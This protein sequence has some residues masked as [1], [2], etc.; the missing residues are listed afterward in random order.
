LNRLFV[1]S[2]KCC[3]VA[4]SL[5]LRYGYEK[6][7]ICLQ[8]SVARQVLS[9]C[10]S[11]L[12]NLK[13]D[14]VVEPSLIPSYKPVLDNLVPLV[15]DVFVGPKSDVAEVVKCVLDNLPLKVVEVVVPPVPDVGVVTV[16]HK[17]SRSLK[18]PH[19][20]PSAADILPPKGSWV[21]V[22]YK[23][24]GWCK[25]VVKKKVTDVTALVYF[26]CDNSTQ[27]VHWKKVKWRW[28]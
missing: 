8:R 5:A 1:E 21:E 22:K 15:S 7:S 11:S 6:L 10:S 9:R 19:I 20:P 27:T 12:H 23:G 13:S 18:G 26:N 24:E 25:G 4:P 14:P 3:D 17:P 2:G 16:V 28:V